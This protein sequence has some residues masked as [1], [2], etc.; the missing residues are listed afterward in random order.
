MLGTGDQL[1]DRDVTK[2]DREEKNIYTI[3]TQF[4]R[5]S[6]QKKKKK[7]EKTLKKYKLYTE[8]YKSNESRRT[9]ERESKMSDIEKET[10]G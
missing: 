8:K 7:K 6:S 3:N 10:L 5:S 1:R 9:S 4:Q 2:E